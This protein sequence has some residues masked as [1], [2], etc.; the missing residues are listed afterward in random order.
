MRVWE[1]EN[2]IRVT[3]MQMIIRKDSSITDKQNGK[4]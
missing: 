4:N 2:V 1:I 3:M